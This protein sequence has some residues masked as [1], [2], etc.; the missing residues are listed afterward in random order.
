M[1]R[2]SAVA[3]IAGYVLSLVLVLLA[4]GIG[5]MSA[6]PGTPTHTQVVSTT[7]ARAA[8]VAQF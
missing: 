8:G 5:V 3:A 2:A 7:Q 6:R 1:N 4:I